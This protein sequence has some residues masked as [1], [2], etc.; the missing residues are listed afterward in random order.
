MLPG[1]A[2]EVVARANA[3]LR[4]RLEADDAAG[5]KN[6]Y[7][8][9]PH[10]TRVRAVLIALVGERCEECGAAPYEYREERGPGEPLEVHHGHYRSVGREMLEDVDLLCR[11]CHEARHQ[12]APEQ[13]AHWWKSYEPYR[14][15][16]PG[17]DSS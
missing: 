6:D 7:R 1:R 11:D 4:S 17:A 2:P 9:G 13:T 14:P 5:I 15:P 8:T 16:R 12:P 10:W 3:E